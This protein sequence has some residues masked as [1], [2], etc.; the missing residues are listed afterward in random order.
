MNLQKGSKVSCPTEAWVV[1]D[2]YIED[3]VTFVGL[4]PEMGLTYRRLDEVAEL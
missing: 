2:I 4:E 1:T 3:G